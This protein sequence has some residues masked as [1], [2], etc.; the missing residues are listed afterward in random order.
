[1]AS[2]SKDADRTPFGKNVYLRSEE[3]RAYES[4]T[5]DS[6]TMHTVDVD[7]VAQYI[8]Q[9]G[10]VLASITATGFVGVYDVAAGVVDGRQLSA[11]IVGLNDT[12]LFW[13][14]GERDV[15]VAALYTGTAVLAWCLEYDTDSQPEAVT[16]SQAT[17]DTMRSTTNLDILFV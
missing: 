4:Y 14:L 8:L 12:A 11:N 1:M 5:F 15:E 6:S 7:G 16:L 3:G 13:Q 10:T 17:A 2:F 9:P